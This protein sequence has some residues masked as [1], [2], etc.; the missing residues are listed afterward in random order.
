MILA[1]N[2]IDPKLR[3]EGLPS[4]LLVTKVASGSLCPLGRNREKAVG[5]RHPSTSALLFAMH[6]AETTEQTQ[7]PVASKRKTELPPAISMPCRN[8]PV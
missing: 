6:L 1:K 2:S 4:G 3:K 5:I 8:G 7:V